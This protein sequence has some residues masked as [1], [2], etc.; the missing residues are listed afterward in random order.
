MRCMT[1]IDPRVSFA[2]LDALD[3]HDGLLQYELYEGEVIALSGAVVR[4]ELVVKALTRLFFDYQ[5]IHGGLAFG[6]SP[7]V[8]LSQ[9]DVFIPDLTWI[10][11]SRKQLVSDEDTAISVVPDLVVEVISRSTGV[12]DRGRKKTIFARHGLPE[13]WLVEPKA[14]I[15]E[16]FAQNEG[17]L[18]L[19]G[20]YTGQDEVVSPT[21]RDLRFSVDRLF[22]DLRSR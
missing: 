19:V 14:R 3:D 4:H 18:D 8:V 7:R 10:H 6:S 11:E 13:F 16:I 21:L 1:A 5:R 15:L 22:A 20:Y 2:E 9:H 17:R 12:R